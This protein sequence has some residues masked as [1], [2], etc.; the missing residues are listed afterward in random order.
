VVVL[1]D[2]DGESVGDHEEREI[3]WTQRAPVWGSAARRLE[4]LQVEIRSPRAKRSHAVSTAKFA[5]RRY[6]G[7]LR[8]GARVHSPAAAAA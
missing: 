8:R 6:A 3:G 7:I 5:R 2:V 4:G 1:L